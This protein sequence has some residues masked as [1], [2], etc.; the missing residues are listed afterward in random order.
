M[1]NSKQR[2]T[3]KTHKKRLERIKR[4]RAASLMKAKKATLLKLDA[5]GSLPK[6]VKERR[7]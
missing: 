2:I 1:P 5:I 7:L 3:A 4:N 6:S